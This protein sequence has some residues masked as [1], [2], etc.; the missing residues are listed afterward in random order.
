MHMAK[1]YHFVVFTHLWDLVLPSLLSV[2]YSRLV[3]VNPQLPLHQQLLEILLSKLK[4]VL[5]CKPAQAEFGYFYP[6]CGAW[7]D[8]MILTTIIIKTQKVCPV[9]LN[10]DGGCGNNLLILLKFYHQKNELLLDLFFSFA[11]T[12][13]A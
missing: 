13:K 12:P 4:F 9:M 10:M 1:V 3:L 2:L 6:L 11:S 8:F 7:F 5:D